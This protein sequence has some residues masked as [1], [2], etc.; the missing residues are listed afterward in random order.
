LLLRYEFVGHAVRHH[1]AIRSRLGIEPYQGIDAYEIATRA[2]HAAAATLD[3]PVD[4]INATTESLSR[5]N[6]N[7]RHPQHSTGLP[8]CNFDRMSA[9]KLTMP[10]IGFQGQI[11]CSTCVFSWQR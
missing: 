3:Q 11:E 6:S 8:Y 4:I 2:A 7:F 1:E 10:K 5:S 9:S